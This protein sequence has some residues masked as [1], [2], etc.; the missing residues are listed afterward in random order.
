MSGARYV[1]LGPP[2]AVDTFIR[3]V[4][5]PDE[6]YRPYSCFGWNAIELVVENCDA[7]AGRLAQH[8][9]VMAGGPAELSFSA[10]ALRAAQLQGNC[11]EML[12]LT[13]VRAPVA[14]FELPPARCPIDQVFIAIV[15]GP[16]PELGFRRYAEH[17]ENAA[18][19][20]FETPVPVIAQYQGVAAAHVYKIGTLALA[21]EHY[22]EFDDAP[23]RVGPRAVREGFL[24]PGIAMIT[25]DA[26]GCSN[27]AFGVSGMR[28]L[29]GSKR[30]LRGE[31]A[32]GEWL[33]ILTES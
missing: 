26:V 31:G 27:G 4:E 16:S 10:G 7:A 9:F 32:F 25:L 13:E 5:C 3:F 11:G 6:P 15:T 33:E 30:V 14:G 21:P 28:E 20:I 12:Y 2:S 18:G 22:L 23:E 8:G 29:Y 17:F 24:P 1:M 19:A